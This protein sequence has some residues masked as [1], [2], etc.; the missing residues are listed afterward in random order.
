MI[1]KTDAD[2]IAYV[3]LNSKDT[4]KW[5]DKARK[6][7]KELCALIDGEDFNTV[8]IKVDAVE[9]EAKAAARKKYTRD[10]TDMVDRIKKP[11]ENVFSAIGGT[12][13]YDSGKYKLAEAL[14]EKLLNTISDIRDGKSI[15]QTLETLWM[16]LYHTDPAGVQY[17]QYE[18]DENDT[19]VFITYQ[20]IGV[21]RNYIADGQL[22]GCILFEPV[23]L[24][25][26]KKSWVLIDDAKHYTIIQ[27]GETFT[28]ISDD[29]T[30]TY[31][32]PFGTCPVIINSNIID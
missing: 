31:E 5:V 15:E 32:H 6:Y 25:N 2:V 1:F 27:E 3:V 17:L 22:V 13:K 28:L 19:D 10:L 26:G 14:Q 29:I 24:A 16:Q 21:I 12:K 9:S 7:S 20:S 11:I 4:P 18:T 23:D 30:K 8:L